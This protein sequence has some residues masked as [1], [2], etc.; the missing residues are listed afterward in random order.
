MKREPSQTFSDEQRR[1]GIAKLLGEAY[2]SY[3]R[4]HGRIKESP[5]SLTSLFSDD[6]STRGPFD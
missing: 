3:L 1:E 4:K 6:D 2:C 5:K